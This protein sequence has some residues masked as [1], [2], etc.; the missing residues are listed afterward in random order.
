[1]ACD[2]WTHLEEQSVLEKKTEVEVEVVEGLVCLSRVC[3]MPKGLLELLKQR[4]CGC[5]FVEDSR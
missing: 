4:C 2:G 1:M 5:L 3:F